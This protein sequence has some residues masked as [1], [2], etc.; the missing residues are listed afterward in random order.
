MKTMLRY[1]FRKKIRMF[2]SFMFN[3]LLENWIHSSQGDK[4]FLHRNNTDNHPT[5]VKGN[6]VI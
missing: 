3:D 1:K 5:F 6:L 4:G 2:G